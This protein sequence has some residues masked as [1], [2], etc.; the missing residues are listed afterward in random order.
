MYIENDPQL[1]EKIS[2]INKKH[3]ELSIMLGLLLICFS[4]STYLA[5]NAA[6][7]FHRIWYILIEVVLILIIVPVYRKYRFIKLLTKAV[8]TLKLADQFLTEEHEKRKT[9]FFKK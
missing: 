5:I 2:L 3:I 9:V 7:L 1:C 4:A 6:S 8:T